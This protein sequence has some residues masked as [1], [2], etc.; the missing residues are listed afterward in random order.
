MKFKLP[1][2]IAEIGINHDGKFSLAKKLVRM[3]KKGGADAV[4]FQLFD[5]ED[6]YLKRSQNF[7]IILLK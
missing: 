5:P 3:A 1:F 2:I 4:K 6:L 7:K